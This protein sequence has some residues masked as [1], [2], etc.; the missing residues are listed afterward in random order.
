MQLM[1]VCKIEDR[2]H[3]GKEDLRPREPLAIDAPYHYLVVHL[4]VLRC[5]L[6]GQEP[7]EK[8]MMTKS[9]LTLMFR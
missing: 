4:E 3:K 5:V 8:N 1:V 2:L 6:N 7:L 9:S